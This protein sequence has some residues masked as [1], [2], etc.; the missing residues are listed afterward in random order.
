MAYAKTSAGSNVPKSRSSSIHASNEPG[1]H[2]ASGPVPGM[3]SWPRNASMVAAAGAGPWPQTT[4]GAPSHSRIGRSPPG[5]FMCG[6]TT[7]SASPAAT[8]AS[9]AF[10]PRSRIAIPAAVASQCV[11]ATMPKVPLSSGRVVK[12]IHRKR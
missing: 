7:C 3:S 4:R 2:A 10:P 8:A 5:P 11:E 1:T 12:T 9:N 6:S